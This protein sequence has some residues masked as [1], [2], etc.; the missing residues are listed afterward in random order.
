MSIKPPINC[1]PN[2]SILQFRLAE[3]KKAGV[4]KGT[5]TLA[6]TDLSQLVIPIQEH[7]EGTLTIKANETK[8]INVDDIVDYWPLYETYTFNAKIIDHPSILSDGTSHSYVLY[9]YEEQNE[10]ANFSFTVDSQNPLYADFETGFRTAFNASAAVTIANPQILGANS[11][12]IFTI[13]SIKPSTKLRH[14][15]TFDTECVFIGPISTP[16][17]L[18]TPYTKYPN[19][20]IKYIMVY[21]QFDK[22]DASKCGCTDASGDIRTNQ[23][24]LQY[25]SQSEYLELQNTVTPVKLDPGV[26]GATTISWNDADT[27]DHIGYYAK[28]GDLITTVEAPLYRAYI[29]EINGYV[30]T[31]DQPLSIEMT[32]TQLTLKLLKSPLTP[33]YKNISD[34]FFASGSTD[35]DNSD[36]CYT[37]TVVLKNPHSFDIQVKYM[38][39]R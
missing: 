10:L 29:T 26:L 23:R 5:D 33:R 4:V 25:V 37:E 12:G 34:Y 21:P 3:C 7:S 35:I 28:V 8:A 6:T 36:K 11:S 31:V 16:G 30:L 14:V 13:G 24:Y 15:F 18:T 32:N 22:V 38:V 39:G 19:G 2:Y 27:S 1:P 20:A 9:D 17:E